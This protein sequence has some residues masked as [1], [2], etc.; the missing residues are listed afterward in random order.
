MAQAIAHA[1]T[2]CNIHIMLLYLCK[3][4][5]HAP[6]L[7]ICRE[8]EKRHYLQLAAECSHRAIQV[9]SQETNSQWTWGWQLLYQMQFIITMLYDWITARFLFCTLNRYLKA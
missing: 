4:A 5:K 7:T 8:Q 1:M 6:G 9:G 2:Q 3:N